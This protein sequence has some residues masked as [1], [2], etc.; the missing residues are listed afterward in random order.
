M[1]IESSLIVSY[2]VEKLHL[3]VV[4]YSIL[5]MHYYLQDIFVKD[6][7]IVTEL[8]EDSENLSS[9]NCHNISSQSIEVEKFT[10]INDVLPNASDS[11]TVCD[12]EVD[13]NKIDVVSIMLYD[14][15]VFEFHQRYASGKIC[16]MREINIF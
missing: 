14:Y 16:I 7:N 11:M 6:D 9:K 8:I 2:K 15:L 1:F 13:F 12:N 3:A 5:N 4:I 10:L